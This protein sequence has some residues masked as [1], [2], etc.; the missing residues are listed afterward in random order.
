LS[1]VPVVFEDQSLIGFRPLAWSVPP[2]ELR[3]GLLNTRERV[4]HLVGREPFLLVRSMLQKL[5]VEG[6][7]QVEIDSLEASLQEGARLLLVS[8]RIGPCWDILASA[9]EAAAADEDLAWCDEDGWLVVSAKGDQ[10]M[11]ILKSWSEWEQSATST[12]CWQDPRTVVPAWEPSL[13]LEP[14][15][16]AGALHRIWDMVPATA[17]AISDDLARIRGCLPARRIWGA[18]PMEDSPAW[19]RAVPLMPWS[20]V[21]HPL[22]HIREA[23]NILVGEDCDIAPGVSIDARSGPVVLGRDVRVL[24]GAFLEG[25]LYIGSG[26]LIKAGAAIYGETSLGAMNKVAGE[27][28]E[29]TFL[30]LANK[31]HEGFIGHAYLGSWCNLGALTTCSDLKNTYGSIRVDLGHGSE[32][33]GQRFVGLLMGEHGKTA[34]GTLFNTGTSVGFASNIFGTGFPAKCLPCFTWGDGTGDHRHDFQRAAA[35]A[36]TAMERRGCRLGAGH[37]DLFRILGEGV[38]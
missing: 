14:R 26:S 2:G 5:A 20:E 38:G 15:S 36:A 13:A 16:K 28:G 30:D 29:S 1:I 17:Q 33:T 18:L 21:D 9:H 4:T 32:D 24:P 7:Y 31:Q 34:I 11:A 10:A 25:P 23:G 8:G 27:I 3:C 37:D 19:A 12:G 35:T 6:G 22:V